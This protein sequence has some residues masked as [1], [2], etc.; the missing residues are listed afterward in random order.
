MSKRVC[1]FCATVPPWTGE[2][3]RR[4]EITQAPLNEKNEGFMM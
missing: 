1:G 4:R 3:P 2:N